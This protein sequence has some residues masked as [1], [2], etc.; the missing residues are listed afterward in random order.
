MSTETII[1]VKKFRVNE[2]IVV[3]SRLPED[4]IRMGVESC[5]QL[6]EMAALEAKTNPENEATHYLGATGVRDFNLGSS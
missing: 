6:D 4:S 5:R 1:V 2:N 3:E